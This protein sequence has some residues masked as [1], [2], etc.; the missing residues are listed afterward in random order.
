M[1]PTEIVSKQCFVQKNRHGEVQVSVKNYFVTSDIL[2]NIHLY[3]N[4]PWPTLK[5]S[6]LLFVNR[7]RLKWR[8]GF[9]LNTRFRFVRVFVGVLGKGI[10]TLSQFP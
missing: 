3:K 7:Q 8:A 9:N 4:I 6:C 5:R 10:T 1:E 2:K